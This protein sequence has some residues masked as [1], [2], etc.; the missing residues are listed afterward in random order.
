[1]T[2]D[3]ISNATLTTPILFSEPSQ[4]ASGLTLRLT[5]TMQEEE[6]AEEGKIEIPIEDSQLT[7]PKHD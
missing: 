7:P 1:M 5:C 3:N 4:Q 6:E 2:Y